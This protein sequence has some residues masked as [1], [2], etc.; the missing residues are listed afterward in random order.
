MRVKSSKKEAVLV[1]DEFESDDTFNSSYFFKA[2]NYT[3]RIIN[4]LGQ[5]CKPI[6]TK[7]LLFLFFFYESEVRER[8]ACKIGIYYR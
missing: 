7:L 5:K 1:Q 3:L 4:E 8:L 2:F 6:K